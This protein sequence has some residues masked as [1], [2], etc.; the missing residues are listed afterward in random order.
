MTSM[1][2]QQLSTRLSSLLT[3]RIDFSVM[4]WGPP[5]IGKSSIVADVAA[6]AGMDMVDVRL[7]QL[8]PTDLRGLPIVGG[9]TTDK[10]QTR[11][12]PP[13]FL[14]RGGT[15]VLFLDEFNMAPPAMQGVAQQLILDRR[16]G[17]Y[18]LPAGWCVWAAGNRREDRASVFEMP[19][20]LA[21]RFIHLEMQPDLESFKQYA[22]GNGIS[23]GIIGFLGARP[24]LLHKPDPNGP[25]WPSPRSWEMASRLEAADLTGECAVGKAAWTEYTA[26]KRLCETLPSIERILHSGGADQPLPPQIDLRFAACTALAMRADSAEQ[27]VNAFTW[28]RKGLDDEWVAVFTHDLKRSMVAKGLQGTFI[29]AMNAQPAFRSFIESRTKVMVAA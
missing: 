15:G 25:A 18:K 11:W 20:P 5:G 24:A 7:S 28:V 19:A 22:L 9:P 13:D 6:K 23:E 27:A 2:P 29:N 26:Y 17:S 12:C 8:A 14:P 16:V 21:N 3:N 10:E 4:I 1:T